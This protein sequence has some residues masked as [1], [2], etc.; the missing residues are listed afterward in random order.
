MGFL[1]VVNTDQLLQEIS[2][3]GFGH[4]GGQETP[5]GEGARRQ[6]EGLSDEPSVTRNTTLGVLYRR[7]RAIEVLVGKLPV[8]SSS[9]F[10]LFLTFLSHSMPF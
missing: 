2:S 6:G 9:L 10:T 7:R 8:K 3:P 5:S 1:W 4:L